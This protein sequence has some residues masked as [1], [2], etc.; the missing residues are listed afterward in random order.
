MK[1]RSHI[2]LIVLFLLCLALPARAADP[3]PSWNDVASKKSIIAFVE[4]VTKEGSPDFVPVAQ[5]IAVF[6]NDGTLWSEQPMPV[7]FYFAIDRVKAMAPDHPEWK[8]KEPFASLLKGDVKAALAGGDRAMVELMMTTHAGMTADEFEK[9]VKDWIATAK[10]PEKKML[11]TDMVYQPMLEVLAYL[12]TNGFKNYIVSGGGIEFMRPWAEKVYGIPPEQVIGSSV[13]TKFELRDGKP[14]IIRL[15]ELNFNDDKA[16]KPVG[17]AQH[18]GRRP[19]M[20]FGNSVGDQQMLEYTTGGSGARF[21]LLVLHDDAAREFPYG[22]ARGLPDVKYGY[23]TPALEEHAKKDGWTVVSMK[24]DWKQVFPKE[25]TAIDILL[26]PDATMLKHSADNNARLLKEYPKGF[27]LDAEHTPHVTMLQ[28][29]VRTA[30]LEKVYAA[31]ESVLAAAKVNALKLEAFKRYYA[32]A[33]PLGVAGICAKPTPEILKLQADIIAA[34]KPFM[35]EA[36]P[37]GAFTAPHGDAA[38]DAALIG[39]VSTFVPK[40]SGGNFNPHVSTGTA[41]KDYLDK[42]LAEPFEAFGFSPAGAA[43][44]QLGPFG[45]AAKKLKEFDLKH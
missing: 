7:Q 40:M 15:P 6:D 41:P 17:I 9:I 16:D 5:R 23:F 39:Y 14:V 19:V 11:C 20:A 13:K 31:E 8:D 26:Q 43:V 25:I 29:Y 18:I 22:P 42:M 3:L 37:I 45:T 35:V 24:D 28:C 33:G 38:T 12:R 30:D 2:A 34:A 27:A 1:P 44:Y 36:G 4:K 32:P 21:G 10:H